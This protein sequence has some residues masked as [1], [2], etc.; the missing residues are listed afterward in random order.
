MP[1]APYKGEA[2]LSLKD[3]KFDQRPAKL[4]LR[5]TRKHLEKGVP[6][7]HCRCPISV[8]IQEQGYQG[9]VVHPLKCYF[10]DRYGNHYQSFIPKRLQRFIDQYD[11]GLVDEKSFKEQEFELSVS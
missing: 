4:Q 2:T 10:D 3:F 1:A 6:G 11:R 7:S 5:I 9:V 8:A